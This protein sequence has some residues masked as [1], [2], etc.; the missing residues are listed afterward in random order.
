M[1]TSIHTI[2]QQFNRVISHSQEFSKVDS[3]ALFD[4]WYEAK[5]PFIDA[6]GGKLI[7]EAPVPVTFELSKEEK[8][9]KQECLF[10]VS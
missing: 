1:T 4:R 3:T 5:K 9:R 7:Y 8:E 10:S 6:W 2:K